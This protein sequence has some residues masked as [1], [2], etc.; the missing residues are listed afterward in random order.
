M[1]DMDDIRNS[2]DEL[3][4]LIV[5]VI[6]HSLPEEYQIRDEGGDEAFAREILNPL[7][8]IHNICDHLED[9]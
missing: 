4:D 1:A 8:A 7:N 5:E 2:I 9:L 3:I 6:G